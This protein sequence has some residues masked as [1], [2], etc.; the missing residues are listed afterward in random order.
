MK[1]SLD[2]KSNDYIKNQYKECLSYIDSLNKTLEFLPIQSVLG[3]LSINMTIKRQ[4]IKLDSLKREI[5][6]RGIKI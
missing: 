2:N 6:K 5:L 1:N 3:R 4:Q